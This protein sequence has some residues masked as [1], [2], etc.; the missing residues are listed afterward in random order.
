VARKRMIDPSIWT[1]ES[2]GMLSKLAKILMIGCISSSDDEGRLRA[3]AP[4]LRAS[5]FPY[6]DESA[7]EIEAALGEIAEQKTLVLYEHEGVRY[8]HFP[9]WS[10]YQ[11]INRPKGSQLPQPPEKTGC[12]TRHGSFSDSDVMTHDQEKL[13]E[14]KGRERKRKNLNH[15]PLAALLRSQ[16]K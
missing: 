14:G 11:T 13:R 12:C 15:Y 10:Q 8:G 2:F 16:K 9:K 5:I 4:Y 7:E 6:G 1:S 3:S